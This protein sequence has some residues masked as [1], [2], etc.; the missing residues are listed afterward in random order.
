MY[1]PKIPHGSLCVLRL[2]KMRISLVLWYDSVAVVCVCV[3]VL[4][5]SWKKVM[6][7]CRTWSAST[8]HI[9]RRIGILRSYR[10]NNTGVQWN[11]KVVLLYTSL[12][13]IKDS[14]KQSSGE[15]GKSRHECALC[16][17]TYSKWT[18]WKKRQK[19]TLHS[20]D[21]STK[22]R[23]ATSAGTVQ[24]GTNAVENDEW[25][26][27]NGKSQMHTEFKTQKKHK[28]VILS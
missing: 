7:H 5:E 27:T 13:I 6:W 22:W 14:I 8:F 16:V 11:W 19:K 10:N 2:V 17:H 18:K 26:R 9:F 1:A 24:A 23:V 28:C 21:K 25:K 3:C 15:M 4:L 20:L 12:H